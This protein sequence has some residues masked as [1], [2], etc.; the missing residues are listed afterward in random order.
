M[1]KKQ[2]ARRLACATAVAWSFASGGAGAAEPGGD[3]IGTW[4]ASAQPVWGDDFPIPMGMPR[5]LWNQTIRQIAHVSLGGKSVRIVLSNEY[6]D[7]PLT[8]AAAHVAMAGHGAAI[9]AG[10]DRALTFDGQA[11]VTIPPGAPVISDPVN[12]DVPMQGNLAVSLFVPGPAPLTTVHW[13]G[14]QTAYIAGGNHVGDADIKPDATTHSRVI[15]TE[16]MVDAPANAR[17]VVLFGDSITDGTDSKLDMNHRWPDVLAERL[18][19]AGDTNVSVLNQ[20]ISGARVLSDRMGSNAL[21]RFNRDVLAQ[22]HASTVVLM[23]GINDIGWP[24]SVLAPH[25]T[26]PTAGDIIAGYKQMIVRA[27]MHGLRIV[28]ATLTP[29]DD[30]FKGMALAGYYSTGKEAK[31]QAVNAFIR[32][33]AFDAVIDFD[34]AVRDPAHPTQIQ[35]KFDS[36]DHLHPEDNG[37]RAMA[38]SIDLKSLLGH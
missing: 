13:E 5:N 16:I 38:E 22:P 35:A 20:G 7:R 36:G 8:I 6:G 15:L 26:V 3:W 10:S 19:Q 1:V 25:E 29:F 21:A 4:A 23:M 32:G 17:A 9:E 34:A 31:R 11:S 28:G 37:Y 18:Q 2:F 12:L 30:A 24:D 14:V 33:G 27:H